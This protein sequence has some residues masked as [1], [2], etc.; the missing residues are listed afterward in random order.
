MRKTKTIAK[1]FHWHSFILAFITFS[2]YIPALSNGFVNWDDPKYVYENPNIQL[3]DIRWLLTAVISANW[4][5]LTMFSLALDYQLWGMNPFGY[6]LTNVVLHT[7]NTLLVYVLVARLIGGT[8]QQPATNTGLASLLTALLFGIHPLH[9]ESVAWISERKDVLCAFFFLLSLLAYLNYASSCSKNIKSYVLSLLSFILALMS[10]PM[11]VSLPIVLLII[12]YYPLNRLMAKD[13]K[14]K[15][16]IIEKLP[17]FLFSFIAVLITLSSQHT[18]E[19]LRTLDAYPLNERIFDGTR[20]ISFYLLKS[21]FPFSLAPFYPRTIHPT[22]SSVKFILPLLILLSVTFSILLLSKKRRLFPAVWFYYIVTLLPVIGIVKVGGHSMADRYAYLPSIGPLLIIGLSLSILLHRFQ[23]KQ[24]LVVIPIVI[25][26]LFS[27]KTMKQTKIWHDSVT[28]WTHEINLLPSVYIAYNNRG[29]AYLEQGKYQYAIEDYSKAIKKAMEIGRGNK[30][31][32]I[33]NNRGNAYYRL[34]NLEQAVC[35]Y[36]SAIQI[37]PQFTVAYI[38]R[39]NAYN[40]LGNREKAIA[41]YNK[42]IE[43]NP[44]SKSKLK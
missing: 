36:D 34:K 33:Y 39:G 10:K 22:L 40:E 26:G 41:D 35:D 9:V 20:S 12:D 30:N 5:P 14:C 1:L 38:N 17:F 6:H 29:N 27:F 2:V 15:T 21:I 7:L 24:W 16:V 4:H 43:I 37:D 42:T 23:K 8:A 32:P 13:S 44:L 25:I 3:L 28:L 18:G 19:A 31:A 11:A